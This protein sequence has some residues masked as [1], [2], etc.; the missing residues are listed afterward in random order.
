MDKYNHWLGK[1][2]K[3]INKTDNY[4]ITLGQTA[5]YSETKEYVDARP[6]WRAHEEVH[7]WQWKRD[8]YI[9]FACKYLWY[10]IKFGYDKNPYEVEA[11]IPLIIKTVIHQV[12]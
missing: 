6:K 4:A 5:Y 2:L 3:K 1:F 7:K 8:G 9:K 11:N 12:L 10:Q